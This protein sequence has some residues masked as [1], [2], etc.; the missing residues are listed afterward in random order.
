MVI[1]KHHIL[2][3]E[4]SLIWILVFPMKI[5]RI[6]IFWIINK[7]VYKKIAFGSQEMNACVT[8]FPVNGIRIHEVPRYIL[9]EMFSE[10]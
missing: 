5:F 7:V 9:L 4:T 6:V 2:Y 10:F 1:A 8:R 3:I